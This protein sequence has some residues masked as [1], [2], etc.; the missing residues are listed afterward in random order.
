MH[1]YNYALPTTKDDLTNKPAK[2]ALAPGHHLKRNLSEPRQ[3][4]QCRLPVL[5]PVARRGSR[6]AQR[7]EP[8][9]RPDARNDVGG[10]G[11]ERKGAGGRLSSSGFLMSVA[12]SILGVVIVGVG[13][14]AVGSDLPKMSTS[15]STRLT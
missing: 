4:T 1:A 9:V 13:V 5:I 14:N 7:D 3:E 12:F 15:G 10:S 11:E 8:H 2:L 6:S